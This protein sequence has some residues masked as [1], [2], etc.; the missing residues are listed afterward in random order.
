MRIYHIT[1][2][3]DDEDFLKK[4]A[5]NRGRLIKGGDPDIKAVAK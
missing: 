1:E 3:E 5:V 4:I 2:W